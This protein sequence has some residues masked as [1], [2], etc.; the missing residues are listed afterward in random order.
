MMK[1]LKRRV[2][3]VCKISCVF[4]H[5][6][7]ITCCD[8]NHF[9][10]RKHLPQGCCHSIKIVVFQKN[11][12]VQSPIDTVDSIS[13]ILRFIFCM[14]T[15]AHSLMSKNLMRQRIHK[16]SSLMCFWLLLHTFHEC[17]TVYLVPSNSSV[18]VFSLQYHSRVRRPESRVQNLPTH[19]KMSLGY[20][21][22][23]FLIDQIVPAGCIEVLL[24]FPC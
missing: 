3:R 19:S 14:E 15:I 10:N 23:C 17:W 1:N 4:K 6:C 18:S 11:L 8:I 12:L 24:S 22:L 9:E 5:S 2:N 16:Y 13:S 7:T 21:I 20:Q